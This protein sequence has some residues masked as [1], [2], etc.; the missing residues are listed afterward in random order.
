VAC[1]ARSNCMVSSQATTAPPEHAVFE[2]Q[3]DTILWSNSA[4][5]CYWGSWV[6]QAAV[7]AVFHP[8]LQL[9]FKHIFLDLCRSTTSRAT[10]IRRGAHTAAVT[11][12]LVIVQV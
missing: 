3:A 11:A 9:L 2:V 8:R 12:V 5:A 6:V 1:C 10:A 7:P 4:A